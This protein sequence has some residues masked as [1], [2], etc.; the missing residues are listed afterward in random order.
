MGFLDKLFHGSK[1]APREPPRVPLER[2][3]DGQI[4]YDD[5]LAGAIL[6]ELERRRDERMGYEL[7]WTLNADFLSG[8]QNAEIDLHNRC[9]RT[10]DRKT[11][12]DRE[13]RVYNR[14]EPL[15]DTRLAHLMS[16]N[17]D[18]VVSPRTNEEEDIA[19]A[20]ISTKLL[21]YC[22]QVTNFSV[23]K[24]RLLAWME[25]CGTAF[26]VSYWDKNAGEVIAQAVTAGADGVSVP[27]DIHLGDVGFGLL[28][29]YEVF[30]ASLTIE[31]VEDQPSIITEQ[32]FDIDTIRDLWGVEV[33][34]EEIES[35]Q[36][37]P[38]AE[39]MTGH[40][41][42]NT[43]FGV[44]RVSRDNC[45]RVV[46]YYEPPSPQLPKGR[47]ILV[48]KDRVV[49]YTELPGGVMPIVAFKAK[50]QAG[51]FYGKSV[52][53]SLIPLQRSYNDLQNK[54]MDYAAVIVNAPLLTPYGSLD[55][56]ALA[57]EGGV[58]S[59]MILEYMKEGGEPRFL[60]YPHF[61]PVLIEQRNQIAND[62]EYTA[63][64]SQLMVYGAAASSSSGKALQ[65][66]QEID[67]TRMSLTGDNVRNGVRDMAK[68]WLR[69][70]KAF[71]TGYRAMLIAG[72]DDMGG[73]WT[74]CSED[75]N[76][77]D[78]EFSA[79]NELRRS[80]EQQKEDFM[81]AFQM[82]LFADENGVIPKEVRRRAWELLKLGELHDVLDIEDMQRKNAQ[83]ECVYF[84]SGVIPDDDKYGD[85]EIHLEEHLRYAL[86]NDYRL[87]SKSSPEYAAL[88]DAHIEQH[89]QKLAQRQQAA[90]MNAMRMAAMTQKG[91][92]K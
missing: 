63:G 32:V 55:V 57:D 24:D 61:P 23:Q 54:I 4:V 35:Y 74:W 77:Y 73:I 8:H 85:D 56:D 19:K 60:E 79:E 78:V 5:E 17:Y 38:E 30:P 45:Q 37:M 10:E 68:L 50:N 33:E 31:S 6:S 22:Q 84:E 28:S 26:T 49:Y 52:I 86:S 53:E 43:T 76:S 69:L 89:R 90:Q 75:I 3:D 16:V 15:M 25:L 27:Q 20:K 11:K 34:G 82:G 72:D 7:R 80:P 47:Y 65:K 59:G 36:L 91:A 66:R 70:N 2:A 29:P 1:K 40:N 21:E 58:D 92:N 9:V 13:R 62:M 64:V 51:L 18:M 39:G 87:L 14:I 46:T 71:S 83:R 44:S 67:A 41:R 12:G 81:Q 88:F 48:I 42:T